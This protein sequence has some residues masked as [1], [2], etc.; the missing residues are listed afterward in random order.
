MMEN[1]GLIKNQPAGAASRS[2]VSKAPTYWKIACD[3][4]KDML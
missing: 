4:H 1:C 2:V 3:H